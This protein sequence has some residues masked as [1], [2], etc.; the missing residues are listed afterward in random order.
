[1]ATLLNCRSDHSYGADGRSVPR[2]A[3]RRRN[4]PKAL[5]QVAGR[6]VRSLPMPALPA[7]VSAATLALAVAF[8]LA[9]FPIHAAEADNSPVGGS[10]L[11]A[12]GAVSGAGQLPQIAARSWLVADATTGE[13]LAAKNAH[14]R[15][16]P[17]STLKTLTAITLLPILD[18]DRE[19]RVR[20]HDAA[21][22]G[23]AVGI[24]PESTYTVDELFY[25]LLLPSGN[26]AAH[27]LTNVA[28][29]ADRVVKAM[30][31]KAEHM[32]ALD[33]TVVNSS[34]LDAPH[35]FTSAYDLALFS[36]EGLERPDFRRYVSTV[37]YDF[38]GLLPQHH[39]KRETYKIYN[40]NPLLL[41]GYRGVLGGKT[42]YT[43]LAGSTFVGA[44]ER[45]GRTLLVTM[46]DVNQPVDTAA[47]AL[48]NWGF[49]QDDDTAVPVGQLM[50]PVGTA[51]TTRVSAATY[52]AVPPGEP[53]P[54]LRVGWVAAGGATA[55]VS[56]V[57]LLLGRL[58]RA[59]GS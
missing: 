55:L 24:A 37:S 36:R 51:H 9:Y 25:G 45:G 30:N 53:E 6:Q 56:T 19:Y 5:T 38:P 57:W 27:A 23:S 3:R 33:T 52:H 47:K 15:L 26:D 10:A 43:T 21:V 4:I 11:G 2:A 8:V 7:R 58:R 12:K 18:K 20:W 50:A 48:L 34:G 41:E 49:A 39:E 16:R 29:G 40:Q 14:L 46:M 22:T 44:A 54:A 13:V 28:G 42:G 31:A 17:A 32:N 1:M 59:Q 35:Q